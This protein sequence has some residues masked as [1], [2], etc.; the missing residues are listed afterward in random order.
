MRKFPIYY[1]KCCKGCKR[2]DKEMKSLFND[3][4]LVNCT[5]INGI[6]IT[7]IIPNVFY[8]INWCK[9]YID[10]EDKDGKIYL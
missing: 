5:D 4:Y 6:G 10:G 7:T 3:D 9:L 2:R 8:I 1:C